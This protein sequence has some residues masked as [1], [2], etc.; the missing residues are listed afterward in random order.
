[1][2]DT[3]KMTKAVG[4][5]CGSLLVF[6]LIAWGAEAV[7]GTS[8]EVTGEGEAAQAYTIATD[9]A[10]AATDTT[11][12]A[13]AGPAFADVYATADVAAGEKT[14]GK[15]KSCH[16]IDGKNATGPHLNGVVGRARASVADFTY[17]EPM[18]SSHDAWTP[19]L[20]NTFLTS[21]KAYVPKTKMSFAGLP[22]VQDRANVI[23][24]LA[25]LQ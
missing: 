13:D 7:F 10:P 11:A 20:L 18:A 24:Y 25:T 21:P 1:M 4:A 5:V 16:N 17:T 14:F 8:S 15:C 2:F 9:E 12:P 6:L 19:E 22:K 3:M 23:A